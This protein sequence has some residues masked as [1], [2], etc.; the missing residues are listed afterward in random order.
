MTSVPLRSEC[1]PQ[2]RETAVATDV[3][4]QVVA[5]DTVG[6]VLSGVVDDVVGTD[7]ADQVGLRGAAHTGDLCAEGLGEL[8]GVGADASRCADD[9]HL[10]SCLDAPGVAQALD[11]GERGDRDDRG[12]LEAE[13]GR[14]VG[15]LVLAGS[16]VLGER[17]LG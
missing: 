10:L 5:V 4:D 1:P 13:P 11:G 17:A 16:R 6:E 8:D 2:P 14:L 12:L 3:E 9:Q 15:E 7:R